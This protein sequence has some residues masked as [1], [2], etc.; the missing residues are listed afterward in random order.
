M[1]TLEERRKVWRLIGSKLVF[2]MTTDA[3][4]FIQR[5][6]ARFVVEDFLQLPGTDLNMT[7]APVAQGSAVRALWQRA[8]T[9]IYINQTSSW[10]YYLIMG[11]K[12]YT[13]ESMWLNRRGSRRKEKKKKMF[14][15]LH[16]YA[17]GVR[18][19]PRNWNGSIDKWLIIYAFATSTS[20][21]F[22]T[23]RPMD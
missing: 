23:L 20:D 14:F 17:N 21:R 5:Y 9:M 1:F 13:P 18:R 4:G 15:R 10:R 2:K 12:I 6:K 19:S 16:K 8:A 22:S 7:F 3:A 11:R